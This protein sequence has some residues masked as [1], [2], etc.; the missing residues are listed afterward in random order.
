MGNSA[1]GVKK[2]Y[3]RL[4]GISGNPS[5]PVNCISL[6]WHG[7]KNLSFRLQPN[8]DWSI[9]V[10]TIKIINCLLTCKGLSWTNKILVV[11]LQPFDYLLLLFTGN[12]GLL[13]LTLSVIR[14][15]L[16]FPVKLLW[17][18]GFTFSI[19]DSMNYYNVDIHRIYLFFGLILTIG[20]LSG[21]Q[22]GC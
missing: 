16:L 8:E 7:K 20:Q 9:P 22:W 6:L 21:L 12:W 18:Q 13:L 4:W 15:K 11:G 3:S 1:F 2:L 17:L 10:T 19:T 5:A 14:R